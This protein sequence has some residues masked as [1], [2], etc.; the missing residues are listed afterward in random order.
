M[1]EYV[2]ETRGLTVHYGP[3]RGI[4]DVDLNVEKGEVFGFLGPNGAGKT[5]ME[6]VLLDIIRPSA[7]TATLFQRLD[8]QKDGVE[9]RRRIGYLPGELA[10]YADMSAGEFFR[11][12]HSLRGGHAHSSHWQELAERLSLDTSRKIRHFSRGNKQKVGIVTAFMNQPELLILDEPTGGLDPLVQQTVIEMVREAKQAGATVFFSSHIL[13]E[14]Q[15]VADRVGIIRDGQLVAIKRVE[16]MIVQH[17]KRMHLS[18]DKAPPADAFA[19]NGVREIER[20]M[21]ID[22]GG[23]TITLEVRGGLRALLQAAL[24]YDVQGLETEAVSLEDVFL[25]YYNDDKGEGEQRHA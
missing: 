5:T 17:F 22:Q 6:R 10:L 19:L 23:Q 1:T 2:I 25:A 4:V 8:S 21:R 9:A 3:H 20:S 12:Y 14:V 24:R 13:P 15:A 7:G 11:M 16:E 18:F